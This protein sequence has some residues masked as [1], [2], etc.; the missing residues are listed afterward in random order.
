MAHETINNIRRA[1][2]TMT[3]QEA[4]QILGVSE[5]S[6]WEE[7]AQVCYLASSSF[8]FWG[9]GGVVAALLKKSFDYDST[10]LTNIF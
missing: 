6:T 5:Q 8:F 3:E 1:S 2:K 7:I 9:G 10:I 4:R